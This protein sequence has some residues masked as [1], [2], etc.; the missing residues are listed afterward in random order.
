[1]ALRSMTTSGC[2]RSSTTDSARLRS[3]RTERVDSLAGTI[4]PTKRF[5][6]LRDAISGDLKVEDAILDGEIVVL[7]ES[8][9]SL[10]NEL[11]RSRST[12]IYAAFDLLWLN[13]D[14]LREKTVVERKAML[15]R[16]IAKK[17]KRG[18]YVDH[19]GIWSCIVRRS[20]QT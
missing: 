3:S 17:A 16:I 7:D 19:R 12:P 9:R 8:G 18:L 4:T 5:S 13:G 1:M 10:F 11:L 6:D 2:S 20:R 14:D 15:K